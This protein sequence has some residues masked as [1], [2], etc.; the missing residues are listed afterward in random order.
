MIKRYFSIHAHF[1]QPPRFDPFT[2]IMPFETETISP[3]TDYNRLIT[4]ECYGPLSIKNIKHHRDDYLSAY[5]LI[6]FNF[7]PTLFSWIENNYPKLFYWILESNII[8]QKIFGYPNAI[9]QV[10]NHS[11]L[12]NLTLK[13]K[14]LYVKWGIEYYVSKFKT[15]PYGMWLSETA[16]DD[17]TLEVLIENDIKFTILSPLQISKIKH[18]DEEK[19]N[20]A[21]SINPNIPYIWKSKI[22][23]NKS[24]VIYTYNKTVSDEMLK[25]LVNTEK[26]L[27]RIKT[28]YDSYPLHKTQ[29]LLIASDGENYGHHIKEGNTYLSKLLNKILSD[30][31]LN[32]IN[33]T[34]FLDIYKPEYE[35]E[36][37]NP[38]SWS[39]P[40]GTNRWK[41]NCGCRINPN[42]KKQNW[43]KTL[44]DAT[45]KITEKFDDFFLNNATKYF[46][47]PY[48]ALTDYIN[49]YH[50][51]NPH[52]YIKFTE[53]HSRKPLKPEEITDVL[54]LFEIQI[55]RAL[56]HVSCGYFFD[57]ISDITTL[58]NIK[59]LVKIAEY[60]KSHNIDV[61]EYLEKL[62]QEESNYRDIKTTELIDR[63]ITNHL[64][65][66]HIVAVYA[67]LLK[68]DFI[69]IF[70]D[71]I[72]KLKVSKEINNNSNHIFFIKSTNTV[73]LKENIWSVIIEIEKGNIVYKVKKIKDINSEE[74]KLK[75]SVENYTVE[76][77]SYL[78]K[79]QQKLI[80]I[81]TENSNENMLIRK[82]L[83]ELQNFNHTEESLNK[84][85]NLIETLKE[86]GIKDKNI[87]FL[88]NTLK[89]AVNYA[90]NNKDRK[91][92]CE[93]ISKLLKITG[94]NKLIWKLNAEG[95]YDNKK[96][97][98]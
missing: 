64:R 20:D 61:Y 44:K 14:K 21:N 93:R 13:D 26:Y 89:L 80:K 29:N 36:I 22:N 10:Y 55:H 98:S 73:N 68:F 49:V 38:S 23:P 15:K 35:V 75:L 6:N 31:K 8:S 43:R 66:Y 95:I 74:E 50:E 34:S 1:Y 11:I 90:L 18:I 9:A 63:I 60:L 5:S 24:I 57:D 62:K 91:E 16:V 32:I 28:D 45:D 71:S 47:E 7:G 67:I 81:F 42:F 52:S 72:Y 25:E 92:I 41:E 30:K 54:E 65:E 84:I 94:F 69:D 79:N 39:C 58:N 87:P 4:D 77:I 70:A 37:K 78:D 88:Y 40:H 51:K 53:K 19:F 17:E 56:S 12:P 82:Y 33:L 85:L 59:H 97:L 96:I 2:G 3:Y 27:L 83:Y 76:D 86:N 46:K 48:N